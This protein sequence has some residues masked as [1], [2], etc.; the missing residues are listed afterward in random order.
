MLRVKFNLKSILYFNT[1]GRLSP[2]NMSIRLVKA[3]ELDVTNFK[4]FKQFKTTCQFFVFMW[5]HNNII[6]IRHSILKL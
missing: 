5:L 1:F 2:V 6:Y 4:T 3:L